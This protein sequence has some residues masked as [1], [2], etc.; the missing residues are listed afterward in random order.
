MIIAPGQKQG[1]ILGPLFFN[2][3]LCD[4]FFIIDKF[5]TANFTDNN[6]PYCTGDNISSLV[7]LLEEVAC[8]IFQWYKDNELRLMQIIDV[9]Y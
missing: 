6:T 5:N 7:K 9:Y 2:I 3:Y 4:L 8:T 1:F